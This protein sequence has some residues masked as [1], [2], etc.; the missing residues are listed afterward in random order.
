MKIMH[1]GLSI[2][3]IS[4]ISGIGSANA[5]H[6][7]SDAT[8]SRTNVAL[9]ISGY[10]FGG[11]IYKDP[12][13]PNN[14]VG[15]GLQLIPR[16]GSGSGFVVN[17]DGTIV[18][19]WHVANKAVRMDAVFDSGARFPVKFIKVYD[20]VYD[21]AVLKIVA[22]KRFS[23]AKLGNSN[24]VHRLDRVLA[25]GN[26]LG[27][28]L[29]FTRGDVS[30]IVRNDYG[31]PVMIRH[32][33]QIAPGNSG[34]PLYRGTAVVGVNEAVN[35][36]RVG[37]TGFA[38]AVPINI[39]KPMLSRKQ[40]IPLDQLFRPDLKNI[41]SRAKSIYSTTGTAS[42]AKGTDINDWGVWSAGGVTLQPL[43]D[44][45]FTAIAPKGVDLD[46][47]VFSGK[48]LVGYGAAKVGGVE[49]V[50]ISTENAMPVN[51]VVL[52]PNG[53]AVKFGF[54]LSKIQW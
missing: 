18:T 17:S 10:M 20:P 33:A 51:I 54:T 14:G 37:Q 44:Y 26:T 15:N 28:G 39:V 42:P 41:L 21:V 53:N 43:T 1:T 27:L 3:L 36:S 25:V 23:S 5:Q 50:A 7:P 19:N 8:I 29:N 46:I 30:Q 48:H 2:L 9:R 49:F 35:V 11:G 38:V 40:L 47:M 45:L 34:G 12:N 16:T 32:T 4:A 52:N 24:S 22:N 6:Y 13:N 31:Q